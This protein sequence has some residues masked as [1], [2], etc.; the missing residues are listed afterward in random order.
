MAT[1]ISKEKYYNG[2]YNGSRKNLKIVSETFGKFF[3]EDKVCFL[4]VEYLEKTGRNSFED[5]SILYV[6]RI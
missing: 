5:T 2:D 3:K 1:T 4:M 6:E